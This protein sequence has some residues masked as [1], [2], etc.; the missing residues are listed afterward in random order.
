MS[1]RESARLCQ[2]FPVANNVKFHFSPSSNF[3]SPKKLLDNCS[4]KA[5][6]NHFLPS[7][8]H[9]NFYVVRCR[10]RPYVF[11]I[12]KGFVNVTGVADFEA[13][14]DRAL[15]LF[16]AVF[17]Q[18]VS[19]QDVTV[20]TSTAAGKITDC[21]C[22]SARWRE[23]ID[24]VELKAR[25]ELHG[26]ARLSLR[27]TVFPGGVIR[28]CGKPTII[29]F[30]SGNYNIVGGKSRKEIAA[31]HHFL[32]TVLRWLWE[33]PDD[34]E[35]CAGLLHLPSPNPIAKEGHEAKCEWCVNTA[36][37]SRIGGPGTWSAWTVP[38]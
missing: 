20:D 28:R 13:D 3:D 35:L 2:C 22:V 15:S 21:P 30:S 32:R 7:L 12:F 17:L 37:H 27:P 19:P 36:S 24:L 34:C 5:Y 4:E 38:L 26:V 16:N 6:A 14:L 23:R 18:S 1:E 29:L 8:Q 31:A 11:T 10:A 9:G 33:V 25:L